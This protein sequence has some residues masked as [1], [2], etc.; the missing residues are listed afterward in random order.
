MGMVRE[1]QGTRGFLEEKGIKVTVSIYIIT[2]Y[3]LPGFLK[4][5]GCIM[6]MLSPLSQV[7]LAKIAFLSCSSCSAVMAARLEE[8]L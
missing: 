1:S 8:C 3:M 7:T 4:D 2:V 6:C 5:N